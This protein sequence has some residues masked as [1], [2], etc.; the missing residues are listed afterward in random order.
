MEVKIVADSISPQGVRITTFELEYP[1]FI[2]AELMTHRMFSRNAQSSRAVPV[3]KATS[4]LSVK[5]LI[6]GKNRPG[7]SSV[8]PLGPVK[9]FLAKMIWKH[10]L[11]QARLSSIVLGKIG[12]H[13]QW[14]N[15]ITE[16]FS[17]IKVVVTS[18]EWGNFFNLRCNSN[19]VQP[20]FVML[21][22]KMKE[23]MQAYGPKRLKEGEW[24]LPYID[25]AAGWYFSNGIIVTK[26][27]AIM[28][29]AA[30]CAQVSYRT[31]DMSTEKVNRIVQKLTDRS[32][33]HLSP[34]EHQA[35]VP[36]DIPQQWQNGMTHVDVNGQYWSGNFRGW[37]QNRQLMEQE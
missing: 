16:P 26:E 22:N 2:H 29:S 23:A 21:A 32:D 19:T 30:A 7:M 37:I 14:A 12:L 9:T 28:H 27:E 13:K 10:S 1:R 36:K 31:L 33:P 20:E 8:E 3:K 35:L 15:R 24:H 34:F 11:L 6:W 25:Q 17:N 5:P 4:L 18:T